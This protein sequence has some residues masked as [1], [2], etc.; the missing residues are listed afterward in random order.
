MTTSSHANGTLPSVDETLEHLRQVERRYPEGLRAAQ[1]KRAIEANER[2]VTDRG[3]MDRYLGHLASKNMFLEMYGLGHCPNGLPV[4]LPPY[5]MDILDASSRVLCALARRHLA[6]RGPGYLVE[7][8][9]AGWLTAEMAERLHAYFLTHEPDMGFDVLV[10]GKHSHRGMTF[11][12]FKRSGDVLHAKLL[13]AQSVDTYYGWVREYLAGA[14]HAGLTSAQLT[15]SRDAAGHPLTDAALDA[16]VKATLVYGHEAAPEQILFLEVEPEKQATYQNLC[17]MADLAGGGD[18]RRRPVILDPRDLAIRDGR[19]YATKAGQER[20]ITK[21]ISRIVD[22]DLM[23]YLK[24]RAA[25]GD[26]A[27][28]ERFRQ[29]YTLPHLFPD[30]SKHLCG[31]YL[32]DKS[33]L[34]DMSLLGDVSIAPNTELLTAAHVER[35]RQDP[36]LLKSVAIKPLHGMSAKGVIVAPTLAQ[37]EESVAREQMLMQETIWAT[38]IQPNVNPEIADADVQAGICSETRLVLQA[39]SPAVPH[40]PY[41]ARVIAGLS[42]SHFQSRDPDRK[43]K[44]DARGRGWYSNVGAIMAVRKELGIERKDDAGVGMG[45]IY[46]VE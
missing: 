23:A 7:R 41:A 28:V 36:A 32:I 34:T 45:P 35:Y 21:V 19:L 37:L 20:E 17:F 46:C 15:W 22:V 10:Y 5:L 6:E 3:V 33:S 4:A 30:L 18:P 9:P 11:D 31:F 27:T 2:F 42:R 26:T 13:E 16:E 8:M 12:E 29:L 25:D 43:I 14:R 38:P 40:N 44:D 39:G 1:T 24:A